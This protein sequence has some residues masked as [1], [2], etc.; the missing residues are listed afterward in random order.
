MYEADYASDYEPVYHG[1]GR[2]ERMCSPMSPEPPSPCRAEPRL[3]LPQTVA[4]RCPAPRRSDATASAGTVGDSP[5]APAR[6]SPVPAKPVPPLAA[7]A[8][9]HG[10]TDDDPAQPAR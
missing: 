1:T 6:R 8:G 9:E 4:R 3:R 7:G 2:P 10:A 5:R